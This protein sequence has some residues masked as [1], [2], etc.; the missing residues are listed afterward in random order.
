MEMP[1]QLRNE[2]TLPHIYSLIDVIFMLVA[3]FMLTTTFRQ[4]EMRQQVIDIEL[5]YAEASRALTTADALTIMVMRDGSYRYEGFTYEADDLT[6]RL[7]QESGKEGK[8]FLIMADARAPAQAIIDV[9]DIM[10]VL[11][12][13]RFAHSVRGNLAQ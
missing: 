2:P 1:G 9:Y 6:E 4:M 12:I 13:T 5:P 10:Q 8:I 11:G 3:F 7:K